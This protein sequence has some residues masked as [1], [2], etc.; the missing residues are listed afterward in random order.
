MSNINLVKNN[1]IYI[2]PIEAKKENIKDTRIQFYKEIEH[3]TSEVENK[4]KHIDVY[5]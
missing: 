5:V 1:I 3:N 2:K 4:G